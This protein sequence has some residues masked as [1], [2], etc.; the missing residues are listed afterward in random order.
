M[1]DNLSN[2][3]ERFADSVLGAV[4]AMEGFGK[5]FSE[6]LKQSF[7]RDFLTDVRP[8]DSFHKG[9]RNLK[10]FKKARTKAKTGRAQRRRTRK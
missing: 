7:G 9:P 3:L 2:S 8:S 1:G 5:S 4:T 6:M 10:K